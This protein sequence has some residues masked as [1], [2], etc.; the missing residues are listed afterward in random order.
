[1]K[2]V[3]LSII[4]IALVIFVVIKLDKILYVKPWTPNVYKELSSAYNVDIAFFGT[5]RI[6]CSF[7]PMYIFNKYGISTY[8]MGSD[9]QSYRTTIQLIKKYKPKIAVIDASVVIRDINNYLP[10]MRIDIVN[11]FTIFDRYSAAKSIFGNEKYLSELNT[12]KRYHYRWKELT[13]IDFI[14][15]SNYY[16]KGL[17]PISIFFTAHKL[18]SPPNF[19]IEFKQ[20]ALI[21][22]KIINAAKESN[23]KVMFIMLPNVMEN[24]M[25][26]I[27]FKEYAKDNNVDFI[28]YNNEE[29]MNKLNLNYNNIMID[30][31]H[32]NM[33]GSYKIMDHLMPFLIQKYT[34]QDKR[35]NPEYKSWHN[36]YI[37]YKRAINKAEIIYQSSLDKWLNLSKYDNYTIIISS[38][39][40]NIINKLSPEIK[41]YLKEFGLQKYETKDDN[42]R[43]VAIIDDGKVYYE[44]IANALIEY[45][46][47]VNNHFNLLVNSDL[48]QAVINVSGFPKSKNKNGLN[49]VIY[50]KVNREVVD[51]IWVDP[52]QQNAVSR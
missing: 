2:K 40:R 18:Q 37:K 36:D 28:D 33:Y 38:N 42:A 48:N 39:G 16:Y 12:L 25:F 31:S 19:N 45:K 52:N 17:D 20:E 13:N 22:D 29:L 50:D 34:L 49:L 43:Y 4:F 5:S 21:I 7:S 15:K 23:T 24:R 1:M 11:L 47:R 9:G 6:K 46:G 8:N 30:I 14:R 27:K 3:I 51:S 41:E 10:Y 32:M 35:N 26:M 44:T